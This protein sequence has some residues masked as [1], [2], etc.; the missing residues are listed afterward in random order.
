M[1]ARGDVV[2]VG[3]DDDR[4]SFSVQAREEIHNLHAG[5]RIER[6]GWLVSEKN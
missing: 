5:V 4:V 3:D 6:A 1:R 2:L